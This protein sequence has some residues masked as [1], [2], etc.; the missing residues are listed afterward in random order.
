MAQREKQAVGSSSSTAP[1][2][3]QGARAT[4]LFEADPVADPKAVVVFGSARFTVLSPALIRMEWSP[5]AVFEDRAS[6]AFVH[7]RVAVP[8]F[9]VRRGTDEVVISTA[10]L[11]VTYRERGEGFTE[12]TLSVVLKHPVD[13][14]TVHW[15]PGMPDTGNLLGTA[16]TLDG[17][18]GAA[19]LEPGILSRDG[20]AVV[21]DSDRLLFDGSGW[22]WMTPRRDV[23]A[24]DWYFF[25]HGRDYARALREF[26]MVSGPIPMVPRYVLGSWFSRYWPYADHEYK[27]IVEEYREH[28]VGLD[29]L[30]LDMDWHLDGWTGYTWNPRYFP[31]APGFLRWCREQRIRTTLN[32]HPADGVGKH[33]SAF[34][35]MAAAMGVPRHVYRIPFDCADPSYMRAYFDVLHH[36]LEAQGVDFW[37]MDWQQGTE[38]RIP[39]LDP[40][41]WLNHLHWQDMHT[42]AARKDQR[43]LVFSRWGGL[44]N[45]RYQIG[46]SGDTFNDWESLA[47]QPYFTATAANVGYAWWSH[48]IGGHQ[49]GPVD[50]ELYVRWVQYG[51]FSPVLRLHSGRE[52]RAERR[53][54][55]FSDWAFRELKES[56]RMRYALV[57]Y[58]YS[59]TRAS[60]ESGVSLC[61]PVYH[62]WPEE[63]RA[64]ERPNQY[65][66]GPD[67]MVAPVVGPMQET[68][69]G[70]PVDVWVPPSD[71]GGGWTEWFT[72][73]THE[74]G[75]EVR[76][77]VPIDEVPIFVRAG[78]VV[79]EMPDAL[80]TPERGPDHLIV[81]IFPGDAGETS[82]YEDDGQTNGYTRD[83]FARTP[84]RHRVEADGART[85]TIGPAVGT[86]IGM[87]ERRSY[88]VRLRHAWP[89]AGATMGGAA[90]ECSYDDRTLT[91]VVR[92]P[93]ASVREAVTIRVTPSVH[94]AAAAPM[95]RGLTGQLALMDDVAAVLGS[96]APA[97]VRDAAA[98][99][100][101]IAADPAG[102]AAAAEAF[103][104]SWWTVV[105]AIRASGAPAD[106]RDRAIARV[107][108]MSCEVTV[109]PLAEGEDA[110][111]VRADL[112]FAPRFDAP[113]EMP[114]SLRIDSDSAWTIASQ[115]VD[116][117]RKM[118]VGEHLRARAVLHAEKGAQ[119]LQTGHVVA[120]ATVTDGGN[121]IDIRA[122]Q[123]FCP[124]INAWW[125]VGPFPCPW[126]EQQGREFID[127]HAIDPSK[128]VVR[129][130]GTE[131]SWIK[132]RRTLTPGQKALGEYR[133]DLLYSFDKARIDYA[134]AYAACDLE[135]DADR[136]VE[137]ALGSDDGMKVWV[138]REVVHE[139]HQHRG[140]RS[141]GDRVI[142]RLKKGRN[143]VVVKI[144][145]AE[146]GWYFGAHVQDLTGLPVPSVRVRL[147]F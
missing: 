72:G 9:D 13:G 100:G 45:H 104:A 61:R 31:D 110:V 51:I 17:F 64:Y 88:E 58:T 59:A 112:A 52:P 2:G 49:P 84:I 15:K 87:P 81:G 93:E 143:R 128:P 48:D 7:R 65:M 4:F 44:G 129:E 60:Y 85:I 11:T 68:S 41:F 135:S 138:N 29:V 46:F 86:Y 126:D 1:A 26:T 145:Q 53:I 106:L 92:V 96:H 109:E 39:G 120:H 36:P 33:E 34:R 130:D 32:L 113:R 136:E 134:V 62:D 74:G 63:A 131:V 21:D 124:S 141:K 50:D 82:L 144:T 38:T 42:N 77:L 91:A 90:L 28:G 99:R 121:R 94:G 116:P 67:L 14:K 75:S 55:K 40:L 142:V 76:L 89:A 108:G 140:Y 56:F 127:V 118:H 102:A 79:C 19:P 103:Q 25:G 47:F 147:D 43:P 71:R 10:D 20:W 35:S 57:P 101:R 132:A 12:D 23:D 80:R 146:A 5:D 97:A 83:A 18:S 8:A 37:W 78:A 117:P 3:A 122:E 73:R 6:Q 114:V 98:I 107:L 119:A 133:I 30:V 137:L 95:A 69:G 16:R 54:W 111:A 115:Q 123:S 27:A 105:D 125:L 66:F 139:Y 70:A 22:A 24:V